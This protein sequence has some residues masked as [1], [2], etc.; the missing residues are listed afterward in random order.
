MVSPNPK[1][2]IDQEVHRSHTFPTETIGQG[3]PAISENDTTPLDKLLRI[4]IIPNDQTG[5]WSYPL[6]RHIISRKRVRALLRSY[7]GVANAEQLYLDRIDPDVASPGGSEAPTYLRI[8]AL[9]ILIERGEEIENF[10][11]EQVSDHSLPVYCDKEKGDACLRR[12]ESPHQA[13]GCFA[14]WKTSEREDFDARQWQLL[15]PYFNL[16]SQ[17]RARHYSLPD[18]SILPWCK[19]DRRIIPS[20]APSQNDGSYAMVSCV[21]IESTSHGFHEVLKT[22][23]QLRP[24]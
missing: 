6:L 14:K 23:S 12:N 9:L 2:V 1:I 18:K 19:K 21:K 7:K 11:K 22:V 3:L 15:V 17:G 16:D 4:H 20:S 8:F 10:V 24:R 13:I 5:F